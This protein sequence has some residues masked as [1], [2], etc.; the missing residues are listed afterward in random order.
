M[1]LINIVTQAENIEEVPLLLEQHE[2][3]N[4]WWAQRQSS[5]L[6]VISFLVPLDK[7]QAV[8]DVLQGKLGPDGRMIVLIPEAV[9]PLPHETQ[10][11]ERPSRSATTREELYEDVKNGATLDANYYVLV[12][13]STIVAAIGL[14]ADNVAVVIG[15]M[16]IAPLLGPNLAFA[17]SS[18]LGDGRLMI[19]AVQSSSAGLGLA[20]VL[21]V[22][23][24]RYWPGALTSN[25][26]LARTN[27][28]FDSLALAL[29]SGAAA[30]LSLTTGLSS[31]LVGVMVAVALLPPAVT[32]G[33]MWGGG[34]AALAW[35]AG[36]L[37]AVNI[38]CVNL[39]A[40]VVFLTKGI[41]PRTW[42]AVEK[43]RQSTWVALIVW[44]L[45]LA[46]LVAIIILR[47][48]VS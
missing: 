2:V 48:A 20:I 5:G 1:R 21:S 35:G 18:A 41:K 32:L 40:G 37:L 42:L 16:V 9:V 15:A 28:G 26:L 22:A 30:A 45:S 34:Q 4:W 47:G 27:V 25:E 11:G 39:A 3:K 29:A 14:L 19:K 38:V 12:C 24:G 23:I 36:L 6:N 46:L 10:E 33:I 7:A 17:L 13:L 43:A 8:M 44:V 31:V